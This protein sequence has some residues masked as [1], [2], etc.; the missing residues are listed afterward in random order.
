M[1]AEIK[2]NL[3]A[4]CKESLQVKIEDLRNE[5]E[6]LKE[7]GSESTKSSAGD[8]YETEV[9]MLHLEKEKFDQQLEEAIRLRTILDSISL[10]ANHNQVKGGSVIKTNDGNF[11]IAIFL[12]KFEVANETYLTISLASPLGKAF[13]GAKLGDKIQF[14]DREYVIQELF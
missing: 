3:F 11:F 8:K 6:D 1:N 12:G 4:Q 14:R 7:A 2:K 9:A 13:D 10:S 5:L